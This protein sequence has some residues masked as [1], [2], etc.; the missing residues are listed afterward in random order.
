MSDL[1]HLKTVIIPHIQKYYTLTTSVTSVKA[2]QKGADCNWLLL[3]VTV[4]E[5]VNNVL[6]GFLFFSDTLKREW[7]N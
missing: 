2:S 1:C 5:I 4:P 7:F 3:A 6:G